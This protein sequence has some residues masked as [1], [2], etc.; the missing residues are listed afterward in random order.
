MKLTRRAFSKLA[1]AGAAVVAAPQLFSP[2]IAQDK[3]LKIGIIAPRSGVA[4]TAGECG[5][6][7]VQWAA[8]RM[9]KDGGIAGRKFE[10]VIEEETNPKDTIERFRRLVLQEKV[11]SVHGLIS[12]GVSLG[13]APVAEEEQSLL[14]MW[15]GTTQDGVKEVMPKSRYVFRSTDNECEA[16]MASLLAVKHFKGKFK[17]VAGINPDYSYG[18]NNWEAFRQILARYGVEAEFVAEQW[19]KVGTLDLTSHIAV[20]KAAKPDLIFSSMLFADLPVFMK[21]GA[22][23]GLFE[24]TKVVLPAAGW[25][26]NQLKK[27]FMPEGVIFGHNTLYFDHPQASPLQKAFVQDYMDK[28]KDAP[29]WEA[30]RAYFALASYKAGVEAAQKAA[31]KWPTPD[32]VA[33]AMP[34]IEVESLGG[35]GRFRKDKIAEQVFYQGPSTNN[36]KYDFPTLASIDTFQADQLQKPPGADFWEWIKTAKLPV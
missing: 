20:L 5:I 9:N 26:L 19:P 17:R 14:V 6:R 36:N 7:A 13:V 2:A 1:G 32:M 8:E 35:K 30:D 18:R 10:L 23:A 3:P 11:E 31:K 24:G 27:E 15:D 28:Y 12:T 16:V 25:Q 4:G 21:Q 29:H 33:E 22:A 34:G